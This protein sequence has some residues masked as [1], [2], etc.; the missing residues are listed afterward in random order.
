MNCPNCG[1]ENPEAATYCA[2]CGVPVQARQTAAAALRCYI[3]SDVE[4]ALRCGNCERPICVKCVVQ[5]PVGIRCRECAQLRK[6]PMFDV[7]APYYARAVGA[8]VGI[9]IVGAVGLVV[10]AAVLPLGLLVLAALIGVGYLVGE[11]ISLAV[12]R[13]RSRELQYI[14][15][16]SV[17]LTYLLMSSLVFSGGLYGL[18]ALAAAIYLA[19]SR[20]RGP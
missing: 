10:V 1:N 19:V 16:G 5:H 12:N 20:L 8:G 9:A 7:S 4:T 6:L 13:K 18:L 15:A 14:A 3:H 11:G 2:Q 17:F